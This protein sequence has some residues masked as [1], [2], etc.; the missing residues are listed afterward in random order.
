[1]TLHHSLALEMAVFL[2]WN[3]LPASPA[4]LGVVAGAERAHLNSAAALEGATVYDGDR[5]STETGGMVLLRGNATTLRLAEESAV[6]G[7]SGANRAQRMEME[8]WRGT[9]VLRN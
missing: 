1:M 8:I 6:I 4:V 5:L 7:R 2:A 3:P 9:P